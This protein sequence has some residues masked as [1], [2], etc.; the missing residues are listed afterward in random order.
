MLVE[1]GIS[2]LVSIITWSFLKFAD[3]IIIP[4]YQ[5]I[6]YRGLKING[7]WQTKVEYEDSVKEKTI[8]NEDFNLEQKGHNIS[9]TY[10][11]RNE[12][13]DGTVSF[14]TYDLK[15]VILNNYLNLT[16]TI[17]SQNE[18]G[19]ACFLL[20]VASGGQ[21]LQGKSIWVNRS[22]TEIL[23]FENYSVQRVR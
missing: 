9:G 14:S 21:V 3:Q 2:L 17:R 16:A 22:G 11:V 12:L 18:T 8:F 7:K 15:G 5:A 19:M 1:I 20:I 4:W 13:E 10:S 23:S 6:S